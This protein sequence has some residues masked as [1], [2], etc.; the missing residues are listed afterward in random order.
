MALS[1]AQVLS[2]IP[3]AY[4]RTSAEIAAGVTPTN[5]AYSAPNPLRYGSD[6]TGTNDS[7]T[8]I[9]N[10]IN[11][12]A[13]MGGYIVDLGPGTFK[14]TG[15]TIS[16]TGVILKGAGCSGYEYTNNES[17]PSYPTQLLYSGTSG[18]I[19]VNVESLNLTTTPTIHGV[20][21]QGM[22]INGNALAA[23][24]LAVQGVRDSNF[25]DVHVD[26]VTT[27]AFLLNALSQTGSVDSTNVQYCT[28][29]HLTWMLLQTASQSAHGIVL[30][31]A[32]L[33]ANTDSDVAFCIF[34][35]C[36]GECYNGICY[37]LAAADNNSFFGC[38]ATRRGPGTTNAGLSIRGADENLFWDFSV[39]GVHGIEILG[40]ASGYLANPYANVFFCTDVQNGTQYPTLDANVSC[41]Y[42]NSANGWFTLRAINVSGQKVID[43]FSERGA[44]EAGSDVSLIRNPGSTANAVQEG[45]NLTLGD[46]AAGTN[47]CLQHSGGQTE[48]WQ[49]NGGVWKQIIWWDT[50]GT[51]HLPGGTT[52]TQGATFSA[53][54]KPGSTSQT[55][56]AIWL[57]IYLNGAQYY[58]P[59]FSA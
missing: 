48:I 13:K 43:A 4:K 50:G 46:A 31:T 30:T 10:A 17:L 34:R 45:A 51:M 26:G 7:T 6:P 27:Q 54:N 47:S 39:Y 19:V 41:Q 33:P 11:V 21:V 25:S 37:V 59:A 32:D 3:Q 40:T 18:G 35:Q 29:S 2:Q 14:V 23:T 44:T 15:L 53:S 28:F 58:I 49:Y 42:H 24:G 55:S 5:Y 56:P 9:Q 57:P 8:A 38:T 52:G 16:S 1:N 22:Y 20:G 36:N 12:A